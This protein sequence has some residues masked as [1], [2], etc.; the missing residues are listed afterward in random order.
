MSERSRAVMIVTT[1]E[2]L[3][4]TWG[5]GFSG[6]MVERSIPIERLQANFIH[7]MRNIQQVLSVSDTRVGDMALDEITFSVEIGAGGEFKLLG[8]GIATEASSSLK[9]TLR[10]EPSV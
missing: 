2:T 8:T 6:Q 7:F 1:A 3:S 9:F 10:R 4:S 5:G